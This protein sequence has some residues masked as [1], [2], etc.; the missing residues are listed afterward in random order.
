MV[1]GLHLHRAFQN[2]SIHQPCNHTSMNTHYTSSIRD[3]REDTSDACSAHNCLVV[4]CN[5]NMGLLC[6]TL[7]PLEKTWGCTRVRTDTRTVHRPKHFTNTHTAAEFVCVCATSRNMHRTF[8]N[9]SLLYLKRRK[10]KK[11]KSRRQKILEDHKVF[12]LHHVTT[13]PKGLFVKGVFFLKCV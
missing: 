7:L 3:V 5:V 9:L 1:H 10:K 11:K 6:R 4:I 12:R 13:S 8:I 2:S